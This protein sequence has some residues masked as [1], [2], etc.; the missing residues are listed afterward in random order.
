MCKVSKYDYS[1]VQFLNKF[2][3]KG[4]D[5]EDKTEITELVLEHLK[6]SRQNFNG[7]FPEKEFKHFIY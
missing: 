2:L 6:A 1:F 3:S 5:V 7:Y 4:S